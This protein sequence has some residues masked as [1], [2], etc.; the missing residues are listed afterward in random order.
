MNER[1]CI[2]VDG[3]N[4]YHSLKNLGI[5]K[6]DFKKLIGVLVNKELFISLFY[7]NASLDRGFNKEKYWNQQRFFDELRKIPGIEIVLTK[8]RKSKRN[9]KMKFEVKGDDVNLAIDLVSGAYESL[10]D[11][12]IIVSGDEDF[13]PAIK[14]IQKL[15]KRVT[16]AYFKKSSS[17]AL[18]KVCD[19]YLYMNSV[20]SKIK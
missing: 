3:S 17:A 9:G 19:D 13:I 1:I 5:D 11:R 2:F 6:I 18:R 8:L 12:A 10:Y 14:K 20:I 15:G 7:Y 16:N 4:L